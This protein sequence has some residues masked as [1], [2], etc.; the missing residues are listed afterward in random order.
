MKTDYTT[1]LNTLKPIIDNCDNDDFTLEVTFIDETPVRYTLRD[2]LLNHPRPASK[3][4]N[5]QGY[6]DVVFYSQSRATVF[7]IGHIFRL[8]LDEIRLRLANENISLNFDN[9]ETLQCFAKVVERKYFVFKDFLSCYNGIGDDYDKILDFIKSNHG[10]I[11][12]CRY[13]L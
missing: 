5:L 4:K 6:F 1:I 10:A 12:G 8:D 3:E 13:G 2:K 7:T 11:T 9:H